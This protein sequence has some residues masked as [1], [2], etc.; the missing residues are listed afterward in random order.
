VSGP[1][2]AKAIVDRILEGSAPL[3]LRSAAAR[4]A[5]PVPRT[6]LTRLHVHLLKDDDEGVR[7]EARAS[8]DALGQDELREIF[9]D[10]EC[11][12]E[13]LGHFADRA[14]RMESLA[15]LLVFHQAVQDEA[16]SLLAAKGSASIIDLILTNQQRILTSPAL[17]DRLTANPALRPDQRGRIL[18][19]LDRFIS[20]QQ[21]EGEADPEGTGS[22]DAT[23][24]SQE[25]QIEEAARILNVDV[26]ELFAASEI[27]GGQELEQ[28]ED[29]V[30]RD[31]YRKVMT[32]NTAQKAILAMKGGRE[33][34]MILVRDTNKVVSLGVL[35]NPRMT[36]Q[37]VEIIAKMRNVSDM[38]LRELGSN[39]EWV[40]SY[41]VITA[42]VYNPKTP[43][44]ISTNFVSRMNVF[45]LK[46]LRRDK[47]VPEIIRKMAAKTLELREQR[48]R[49]RFLKK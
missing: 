27:M 5:I 37:D 16:L 33:E 30:I 40:K 26:G 1:A 44:G 15:E 4:G 43:P 45:D 12:G 10:V 19:L 8:L 47:N 35:R 34:R 49:P 14:L 41:T 7:E 20:K 18:D 39:R 48:S 28:S 38:V 42:L 25:E 17:L 22:S 13:V 3:Q 36:K 6:A 32:L 23:P 11:H 21:D 24:E 9:G 2:P 46:K 31:A 29:P